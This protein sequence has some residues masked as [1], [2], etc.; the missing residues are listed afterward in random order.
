MRAV[1]KR[2]NGAAQQTHTHCSGQRRRRRPG[3]FSDATEEATHPPELGTRCARVAVL[4]RVPPLGLLAR[5][6]KGA[7]RPVVRPRPGAALDLRRDRPR[8]NRLP[9]RS[10][11]ASQPAAPFGRPSSL[12]CLE[13]VH[14]ELIR[15]ERCSVQVEHHLLVVAEHVQGRRQGLGR[16]RCHLRF[17]ARSSS[18][19]SRSAAGRLR[20]G[21]HG[22]H[23]QAAAAAIAMW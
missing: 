18:C 6:R 5:M 11:G 8:R 14:A 3:L 13:M 16:Q 22:D 20:P 19:S 10:K 17:P 23:R 4:A 7:L 2:Q 1:R 9:M 21:V 12:A 15:A